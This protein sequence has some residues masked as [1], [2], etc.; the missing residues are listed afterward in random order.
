MGGLGDVFFE[1]DA[2]EADALVGSGDGFLRV[3]G[4]AVI[5]EGDIAAD[6]KGEIHLR[7]LVVFRHVGVEV[8]FPIP[9]RDWRRGATEEHAC[10]DGFLDGDA[11]E[12]GKRAG[13]AETGGADVDVGFIAKGGGAGAEHLGLRVDLA[14]DFEADGDEVHFGKL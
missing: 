14:V 9:L 13:E 4:V 3:R 12:H 10:E 7:G 5:V 1:V 11:I 8:V 2:I 6:A